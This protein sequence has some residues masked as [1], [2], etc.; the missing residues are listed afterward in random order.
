MLNF[1]DATTG[2]QFGISVFSY[3]YEYI[4]TKC[5]GCPL[6]AGLKIH[7]KDTLVMSI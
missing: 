4:I 1:I 5:H 3:T 6:Y 7:Y 2:D